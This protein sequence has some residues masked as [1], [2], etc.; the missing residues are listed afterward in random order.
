MRRAERLGDPV[1]GRDAGH[2]TRSAGD[3][4]SRRSAGC[5][6]GSAKTGEA[7]QALG[8]NV[9]GYKVGVF[10]ITAGAGG[11]AGALLLRLAR[12]RHADGLRVLVLAHALRDR[13]LRRHGQPHRLDPRR[14]RGHAARARA[15]AA[16]STSTRRRR[17]SYQLVVYGV[18]LVVLMLVRPQGVLPE[19]FSIWRRLRYGRPPHEPARDGRDVGAPSRRPC[20]PAGCD[21]DRR[22]GARPSGR[23]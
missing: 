11:L 20:A 22:A 6:R 21:G 13:D 17:A 15:R 2:A 4:A 10:G 3:S 7:T 5:S 23:S 12:P 14:R 18:A 1:P 8:K 16:R 19:G 9:F